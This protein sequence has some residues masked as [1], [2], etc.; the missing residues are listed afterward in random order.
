MIYN[1]KAEVYAGLIEVD[2]Y[3]GYYISGRNSRFKKVVRVGESSSLY[4]ILDCR[5]AAGINSYVEVYITSENCHHNTYNYG[6]HPNGMLQY[7][8]QEKWRKIRM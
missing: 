5:C 1:L 2:G 7:T 6:R 8:P 3:L 4:T